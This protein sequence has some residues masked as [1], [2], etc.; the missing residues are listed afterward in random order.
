MTIRLYLDQAFEYRQS[1]LQ[2]GAKRTL[3][4]RKAHGA[5]RTLKSVLITHIKLLSLVSVSSD[6]LTSPRLY[7]SSSIVLFSFI[8]LADA[9]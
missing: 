2:E 7:L 5:K 9:Y 3:T 8:Y 1:A 4:K 6:F